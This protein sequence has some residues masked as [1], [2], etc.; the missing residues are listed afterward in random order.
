M[1][2]LLILIGRTIITI[3]LIVCVIALG[4][5]NN[6]LSLGVGFITFGYYSI[7]MV[8]YAYESCYP[9]TSDRGDTIDN[10]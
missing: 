2:H 7:A 8:K 10:K 4:D 6:I 3:G 5:I 9:Q 1:K